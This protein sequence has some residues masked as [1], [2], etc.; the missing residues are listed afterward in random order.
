MAQLA[1]TPDSLREAR[2]LAKAKDAFQAIATFRTKEAA[3]ETKLDSQFGQLGE[4]FKQWC[5]VC[6]AGWTM[7]FSELADAELQLQVF[8]ADEEK[9]TF[10]NHIASIVAF[11]LWRDGSSVAWSVP[12]ECIMIPRITECAR[13]DWK[14]QNMTQQ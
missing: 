14:G 13:M 6:I 3:M 10:E 12:K 2:L 4:A 7:S 11:D 1:E 5:D 9:T 8:L